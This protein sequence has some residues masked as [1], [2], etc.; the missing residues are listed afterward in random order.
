MARIK[1]FS[2]A[3]RRYR[4]VCRTPHLTD[5]IYDTSEKKEA[6]FRGGSR[7]FFRRGCTR[8]L[9]YFNTNKTHSFFF[10][11][12]PVV[13]E[14]R[15]S[16]QEEGGRGAHPLHPPPRSFPAFWLRDIKWSSCFGGIV[17]RG[18]VS[19]KSFSWAFYEHFS[20]FTETYSINC[21]KSTK[22]CLQFFESYVG[23]FY[24]N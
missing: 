6:L 3:W 14:N 11:R 2:F 1:L 22:R 20:F 24:A 19:E 17:V 5:I 13:L 16:S 10:C 8:L 21:I 18:H 12:I 4:N 15:R 7:I 9:L 23:L